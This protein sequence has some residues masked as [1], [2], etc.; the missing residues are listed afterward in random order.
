V[1]LLDTIEKRR[2]CFIAFPDQRLRGLTANYFHE[3]PLPTSV[4]H[5]LFVSGYSTI[6]I[7]RDLLF[8]RLGKAGI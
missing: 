8:F 7:G 2:N 1:P 6:P 4:F 3:M 5:P